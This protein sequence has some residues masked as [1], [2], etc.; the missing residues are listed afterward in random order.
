MIDNNFEH[1]IAQTPAILRL[2]EVTKFKGQ[3][4]PEIFPMTLT[5]LAI[6]EP[7]LREL[8]QRWR[9]RY[10]IRRA[11]WPDIALFRSLNMAHQASLLPA[12]GDTTFYDVGRSIALWVSAFEILVHPG[13]NERADLRK[14]FDLIERALWALRPSGFRRFSTGRKG[15][16]SRRTRASWIYWHLYKTRNDFLHGNPVSQK[17]LLFM[18]SKRNLFD[19]AGPLYRLALTAFLPLTFTKPIPRRQNA[20]ELAEYMADRINFLGYQRTIEEGLLTA[21]QKPKD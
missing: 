19:Y 1:M 9:R 14:V 2:H 13:T 15:C 6:D 5:P 3:S 18:G 11:A 8:L 20:V 16:K 12:A 7:L 4:S 21:R 17:A 10:T